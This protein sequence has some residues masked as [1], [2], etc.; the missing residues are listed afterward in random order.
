MRPYGEAPFI[1]LEEGRNELPPSIVVLFDS[2]KSAEPP[3]NS[4]R[5]EAMPLITFPDAAR[6]AISL[7]ESNVGIELS[8]PAG[9]SFFCNLLRSDA[10]SGF[11][12]RQAANVSSHFKRSAVPR[13]IT[14]RA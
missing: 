11:A 3:Q 14:F 10:F 2:A 5:T 6:V 8:Q 13:S 1:W 9:S 7:S 12:V 4:G